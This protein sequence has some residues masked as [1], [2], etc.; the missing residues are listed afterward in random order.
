MCSWIPWTVGTVDRA[1]SN[2]YTLANA[3]LSNF[4]ISS[5]STK[6]F[7]SARKVPYV[8]EGSF[9]VVILSIAFGQRNILLLLYVSMY[10]CF[11]VQPF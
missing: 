11:Y 10:L 8:M 7:F 6:I 9:Q 1:I 5:F 3:M 4:N 2:I